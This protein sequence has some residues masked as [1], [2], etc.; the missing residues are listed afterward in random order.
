MLQPG[1]K[2][3]IPVLLTV[4]ISLKV[5]FKPGNISISKQ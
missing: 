5:C 4:H 3:L 1:D 2:P